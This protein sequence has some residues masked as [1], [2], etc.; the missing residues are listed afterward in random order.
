MTCSIE[1]QIRRFLLENFLFTDDAGQLSDHAS[2][3]EEGVVDS[4][5][6]LEVVGFIEWTFGLQIEDREIVPDNFD[7][8]ARL[9]KF[10]RDKQATADP[11]Q[12]A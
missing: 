7:S 6:V 2:L 9:A 8:V 3:L 5:G 11:G 12:P 4:T 1:D 10:V